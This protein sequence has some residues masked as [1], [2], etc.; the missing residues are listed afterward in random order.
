MAGVDGPG[1]SSKVR[2]ARGAPRGPR[3]ST[4]PNRGDMGRNAAHA[5]APPAATTAAAMAGRRRA[6]A[7]AARSAASTATTRRMVRDLVIGVLIAASLR[8]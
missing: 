3:R 6:S 2:A 1:P 7:A 5:P 4:G 8:G